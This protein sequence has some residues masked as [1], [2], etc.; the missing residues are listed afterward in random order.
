[1]RFTTRWAKTLGAVAAGSLAVS[2]LAV[3]PAMAGTN[4]F[5]I[6][7]VV[8]AGTLNFD[9]PEGNS[10]E[11][12]PKN[13]ND[14]KALVIQDT[15]LP[16]LDRTNPNA[17]T[18]MTQVWV[19]SAVDNEG[20]VWGY[21]AFQIESFSTGQS[22]WEFMAT[23]PP[24]DCDYTQSD[25]FLIDNCNPWKFRADGDFV[26]GVDYQ[27]N[28][29]TLVYREWD[30][31]PGALTLLPSVPIPAGVGEAAVDADT[32]IV[33]VAV[34]LTEGVF[35]NIT[36]CVTIGNI[37]PSTLT[38][39]SDQADYKDVVLEPI[40]EQAAISNCGSV[41]IIKE[42]D[43]A[44]AEVPAG[45]SFAWTLDR[46][47]GAA[48]NYDDDTSATGTFTG[49]G[50]TT[51]IDLIAGTNYQLDESITGAAFGLQSITCVLD[52][53]VDVTEPTATFE[54]AVGEQTVCTIVN[55]QNAGELIVNKVVTKDN[56]GT[57]GPED[58]SFD[59][60]GPT[61]S[62]NN[63]FEEDGS[64]TLT[65]NAGTYNVTET[66]VATGYEEVSNDCVD[67]VVPAG[68]SASCTITNDDLAPSL[69][70]VKEVT[71]D[72]GG[73]AVATDFELTATGPT[74]ISGDGGATS[75]AS[76]SAGSY[77]LSETNVDGYN[78]GEWVCT[79]EGTQTGATI[80]LALGE[81]ATCT[82]INN[83]T[84]ASPTGTTTMSWTLHDSLAI[85]GLRADAPNAG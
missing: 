49:A 9:D 62:S 32:G 8:D 48:I 80:E 85:S 14:Y 75:D 53:S 28:G 84:P 61:A 10:K 22:A 44:D 67:V 60:A 79:G 78:A 36:Q 82:I 73:E 13:G 12:G 56:G 51:V 43:P 19:D 23:P 83:D 52:G 64:N 3:L 34:N 31:Q 25:Q 65:V 81:S 66:G 29:A 58:F 46:S 77:A 38:G 55:E 72:N 5:T 33:E 47:G 2:G 45:N 21:F 24:P 39:N 18:D 20:D 1:M 40:G 50:E 41:K 16:V 76:F 71:N 74:S 30:G 11:L 4:P 42:L 63:A 59:V 6:D 35:G 68:G 7:G 27:G 26:I 54:V 69:T 15:P 70:L 57:A 17:G 37:I